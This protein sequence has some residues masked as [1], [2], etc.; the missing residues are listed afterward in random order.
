M[1]GGVEL[2]QYCGG[3]HHCCDQLPVPLFGEDCI[4]HVPGSGGNQL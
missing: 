3:G 1:G 4:L 2:Y